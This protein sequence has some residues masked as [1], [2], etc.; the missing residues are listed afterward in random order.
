MGSDD[1]DD[2]DDVLGIGIVV[3]I[4][5]FPNLVC[6]IEMVISKASQDFGDLHTSLHPL[7]GGEGEGK[8]TQTN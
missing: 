5:K 4:R 3:G 1:D 7:Q 2:D 6:A 8:R